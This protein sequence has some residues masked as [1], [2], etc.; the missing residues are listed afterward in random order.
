VL[1]GEKTVREWHDKGMTASKLL[2][3]ARLRPRTDSDDKLF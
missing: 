2:E 3:Y 1:L